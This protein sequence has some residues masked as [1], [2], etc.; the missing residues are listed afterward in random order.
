LEPD[1]YGLLRKFRPEEDGVMFVISVKPLSS[2]GSESEIREALSIQNQDKMMKN[3][4]DKLA[5]HYSIYKMDNL[6][7]ESNYSFI[8][9]YIFD[10]KRISGIESRICRDYSFVFKNYYFMFQGVILGK[11]AISDEKL[12]LES[13]MKK[14]KVTF[15]QIANSVIIKRD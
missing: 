10:A 13:K 15:D 6:F 1:H 2:Q 12:I 8:C 7:I 5:F 11:G 14:Y 9:D 3:Q 4:L